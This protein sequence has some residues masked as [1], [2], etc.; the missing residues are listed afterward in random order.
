L[1]S[2]TY[3]WF[4]GQDAISDPTNEYISSHFFYYVLD[5]QSNKQTKLLFNINV[6]GKMNFKA[7]SFFWNFVQACQRFSFMLKKK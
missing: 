4:P 6:E 1:N 3:I 5:F 7:A 2:E